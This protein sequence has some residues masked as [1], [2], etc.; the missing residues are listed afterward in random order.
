MGSLPAFDIRERKEVIV[1]VVHL[2]HCDHQKESRSEKSDK[3]LT[4]PECLHANVFLPAR[5]NKCRLKTS[6]P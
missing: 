6:T 4:G 3:Q 1:K 5:E 2:Y